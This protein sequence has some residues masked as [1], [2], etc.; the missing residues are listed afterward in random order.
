MASQQVSQRP[1]RVSKLPVFL[2]ESYN[3]SFSSGTESQKLKGPPP[4]P[5]NNKE[6]PPSLIKPIKRP[7]KVRALK[8]AVANVSR[9]GRSRIGFLI[10]IENNFYYLLVIKEPA[11]A[12]KNVQV[13]SSSSTTMLIKWEEPETYNGQVIVRIQCCASYNE[14]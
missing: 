2:Q 5:T 7:R 1:K 3:G 12:P 10:G 9:V 8:P 6:N 4:P 11:P 14:S 13:R